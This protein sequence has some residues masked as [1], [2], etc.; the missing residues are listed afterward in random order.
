V[1]AS[2]Y[3]GSINATATVADAARALVAAARGAGIRR[4]VVVGGSGILEVAPGVQLAD[5]PGFS[6]ILKPVS[7]AH[8]DAVD[9]FHEA[10]DLDWNG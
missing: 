3:R 1:L 5:T 6:D 2:A 4:I 8:Q 9:V 10:G 7:L